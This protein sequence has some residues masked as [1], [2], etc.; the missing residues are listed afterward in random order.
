[1]P[2]YHMPLDGDTPGPVTI[3]TND[4]LDGDWV[5][6]MLERAVMIVPVVI[7]SGKSIDAG[8]TVDIYLQSCLPGGI[9]HDLW[10]AQQITSAVLGNGNYWAGRQLGGHTGTQATLLAAQDKA[11]GAG[12][13]NTQEIHGPHARMTLV[14]AAFAGADTITIDVWVHVKEYGGAR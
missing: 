4:E 2:W 13:W 14:P 5:A 11:M 6:N 1:M 7:I 10:H 12:A 8:T 3:T 9:T